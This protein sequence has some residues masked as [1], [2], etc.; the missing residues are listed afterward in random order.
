MKKIIVRLANGLGNQLFTYAAAYACAKKNNAQLFVDEESGFYKRH[1]YELNNFKIS[2]PIVEKKHKFTGIAGRVR[3]KILI[4]VNYLK[5]NKNFLIE[6]RNKNKLTF[7]DNNFFDTKLSDTV[8]FE[9]Y[10]QT[11]KYFSNSVSSSN[12]GI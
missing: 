10:Y 3:R 8:Y 5:K 9:G 7:Y 2:S 1:K 6:K 12:Q 11:E 4:K